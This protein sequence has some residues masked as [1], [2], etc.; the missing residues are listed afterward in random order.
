MSLRIA[1]TKHQLMPV[2]QAKIMPDA[3]P[4]EV[5]IDY[6]CFKFQMNI[7]ANGDKNSFQSSS[8]SYLTYLE[9]H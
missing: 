3:L 5:M 2:A 4:C 6:Y 9:F 1:F 8:F 7:L